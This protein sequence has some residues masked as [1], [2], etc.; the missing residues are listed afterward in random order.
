MPRSLPPHECYS[1]KL[2]C[3]NYGLA[4]FEP[5]PSG[6][7]DFVR[8]GDVGYMSEHGKFIKLF[9]AFSPPGSLEN[10]GFGLPAGF[11]PIPEVYQKKTQLESLQPGCRKSESV[12]MI[13]GSFS[14]SGSVLEVTASSSITLSCSSRAGAALITKFRATRNAALASKGMEDYMLSNCFSWLQL[15]HNLGRPVSLHDLIFVRECILTGDWANISWNNTVCDTDISFEAG[16]PGVVGTELSFWGQ[17]QQQVE[18]PKRQGPFRE[19]PL[20]DGTAPPFDQCIFLKGLR[21]FERTWYEKVINSLKVTSQ[22]SKKKMKK[23]QSMQS[24]LKLMIDKNFKVAPVGDPGAFRLIKSTYDV[25]AFYLFE[26]SDADLTLIDDNDVFSLGL[27][28]IH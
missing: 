5:N 6:D 7:Y 11:E 20:S 2:S 4:L 27:M 3:L 17:W 23:M 16:V 26:N 21:L 25:L 9:N 12:R 28:L 8:I 10:R 15:A 18:V 22:G 1:L 19:T 24:G 14:I 13:A